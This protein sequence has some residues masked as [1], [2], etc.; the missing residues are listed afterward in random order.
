MRRGRAGFTLIELLAVL[1]VVAIIAGVVVL[2]LSGP[3]RS[4]RMR[5]V[6]G[7]IASF[8]RLT[9]VEAVEMDRAQALVI[10]LNKGEI[11]RRNSRARD[12]GGVS[13]RL[14]SEF[15]IDRVR[16][17]GR[18]AGVGRVEVAFSRLG[19]APSYALRIEGPGRVSR[20]V[21]FCGLTGEA[22]EVEDEKEID[23]VLGEAARRHDA[24]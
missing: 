8:D 15:R 24:G 7:E 12:R 3:M 4:A 21:L 22:V 6:I 10:D 19:Y 9:R 18:D 14:P 2:R 11:A 17:P 13:L 1:V 23:E 16:L 20:W 5:D